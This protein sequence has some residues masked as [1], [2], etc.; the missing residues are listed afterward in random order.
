MVSEIHDRDRVDVRQTSTRVC[1]TL[2]ADPVGSRVRYLIYRHIR[3]CTERMP[4]AP[5]SHTPGRLNR[6]S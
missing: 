4:D 1:C 3:P 2:S 6:P 5:G